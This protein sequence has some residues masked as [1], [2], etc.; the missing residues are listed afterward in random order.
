MKRKLAAAVLVSAVLVLIPSCIDESNIWYH[1]E[2]V[3][4]TRYTINIT[5]DQRYAVNIGG[6]VSSSG[7]S[8]PQ[9]YHTPFS[10][11][12]NDSKTVS[13]QNSSAKFSWTASTQDDNRYIIV[14]SNGNE[15][16]FRER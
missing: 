9:M 3:N 13:V 6:L 14:S 16:T 10:V 4:E 7:S 1:Y 5:L 8:N 11:N 15:A 2:F 12:P